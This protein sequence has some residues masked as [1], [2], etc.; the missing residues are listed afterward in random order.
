MDLRL[1]LRVLRRFWYV[2]LLGLMLAAGLAFLAFVRVDY[3][4]GKV[5]LNYPA[6]EQWVAHTTLMIS[7]AGFPWG[8][9]GVPNEQVIPSTV[10]PASAPRSDKAS[11]P[12][13]EGDT[14]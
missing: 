13:D 2:T 12:A 1:Y 8:S 3:S 14:Y 10:P 9:A 4:G 6:N 11:D 7:R 5:D